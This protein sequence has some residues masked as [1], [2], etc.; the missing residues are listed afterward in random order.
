[1]VTSGKVTLMVGVDV[2]LLTVTDPVV[3]P[4]VMVP[5]ATEVTPP[6][7]AGKLTLMVGTDAV[8]PI[9]IVP[10]DPLLVTVPAA[11]D[12]T[13][14]AA[15]GAPVAPVAPVL[16]VAPPRANTAHVLPLPATSV[17]GFTF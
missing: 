17:A 10:V 12:V 2:P 11:M 5:G 6:E 13:V 16:P 8:P 4:V 15:P 1:M 14:P 9:E 3:P 7:L